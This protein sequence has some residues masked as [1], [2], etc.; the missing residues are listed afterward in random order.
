MAKVTTASYNK[1][2]AVKAVRACSRMSRRTSILLN[3]LR[4]LG[5]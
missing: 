3:L 2:K 4:E 5:C 1:F